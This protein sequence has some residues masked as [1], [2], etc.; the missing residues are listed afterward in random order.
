MG[1]LSPSLSMLFTYVALGLW[2][3]GILFLVFVVWRRK[4]L[5]QGTK[6]TWSLF[7]IIMPLFAFLGY[8]VFGRK[9]EAV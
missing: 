3:S 4:D 1:L 5:T 7:F 8:A 2:L 9:K 6:I